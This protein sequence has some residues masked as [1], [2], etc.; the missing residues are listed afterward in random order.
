[1]SISEPTTS[2]APTTSELRIAA[3]HGSYAG[4][5][6]GLPILPGAAL[7]DAALHDIARSRRVDLAYWELA[8]VKF[9]EAV[10]PGDPLTLEHSAPNDAM[11]RFAIRSPRAA[12]ASGTLVSAAEPGDVHGA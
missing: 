11:I 5:F 12:V 10:R 6:P 1:M 2:S 4:H 7:L 8:A 3:D 9:L